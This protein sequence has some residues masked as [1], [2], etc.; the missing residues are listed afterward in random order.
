MPKKGMV[1]CDSDKRQAGAEIEQ[2]ER[3]VLAILTEEFGDARPSDAVA[4]L[5][6]QAQRIASRI[7]RCFYSQR[8]HS[9]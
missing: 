7:V 1:M 3:D 2:A 9:G 5:Q 6:F 8:G 4:T